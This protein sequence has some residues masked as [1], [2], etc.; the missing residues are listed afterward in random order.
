MNILPSHPNSERPPRWAGHPAPSPLCSSP[1]PAFLC[2]A[3]IRPGWAGQ[4]ELAPLA[5][6]PPRPRPVRARSKVA[7]VPLA[8]LCTPVPR[9]RA[10]GWAPAGPRARA[11]RPDP[12][13]LRPASG[14]LSHLAP[15]AASG[16]RAG[17][18]R[19]GPPG[20]SPGAHKGSPCRSSRA[21]APFRGRPHLSRSR[22]AGRWK[23]RRGGAGTKGPGR[24][25]GAHQSA[26]LSSRITSSYAASSSRRWPLKLTPAML[27]G[28]RRP[29]DR[30]TDGQ[31]GGGRG[32]GSHRRRRLGASA[33]LRAERASGRG[34]GAGRRGAGGAGSARLVPPPRS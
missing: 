13:C 34:K 9:A 2:A 31:T 11:T 14:R 8:G 28:G 17:S 30:C 24:G 5:G 18:A 21:A 3:A 29:N 22:V 15:G 33:A 20:P 26:A 23:Q 19:S 4:A 1:A 25:R 16:A 32:G 10:G 7:K 27:R 6:S 12:A